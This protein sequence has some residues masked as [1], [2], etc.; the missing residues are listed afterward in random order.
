MKIKRWP[1]CC[2]LFV[3]L[4]C[5]PAYAWWTEGH[6]CIDRAAVSVLPPDMPEFFRNGADTIVAYSMDPDLWRNRQTECLKSSEGPNHFLDLELLEGR[7]L[8]ETRK[9]F[10]ALCRK[11]KLAP[12]KVGA[13]PYAIQ[14]WHDRLTLALAEHRGWPDDRAVKAKVLYIAGI[15]SHYTG[16]ATQPLHCTIHYDGR[17]QPDGA[18][19]RT[20]IHLKMDALPGH[21]GTKP[22]EAAKGLK[23]GAAKDVFALTLAAIKESNARVARVYKLENRLP[24]AEGPTPEAADKG[25]RALS[26]E[27]CKAGASLTATVWYSAWAASEA[28]ELHPWRK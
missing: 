24:A 27:C 18:S 8:P 26:T 11:L 22:D 20:G 23:I 12:D 14:E 5:Q 2:L 1:A 28:V 16:D 9:E 3:A 13:L 17:V 6:E 10:L 21:M 7:P 4:I 25:V 19:P 15:L